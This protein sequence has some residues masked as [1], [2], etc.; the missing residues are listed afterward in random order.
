MNERANRWD[1]RYMVLDVHTYSEDLLLEFITAM[2]YSKCNSNSNIIKIDILM[3]K[4]AMN[5]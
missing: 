5:E 3:R 2:M 4:G 1:K